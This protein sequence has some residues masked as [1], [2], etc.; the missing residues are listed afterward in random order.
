MANNLQIENCLRLT[1]EDIN[2]E[3]SSKK[4]NRMKSLFSKCYKHDGRCDSHDK[5]C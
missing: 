5:K 1:D 4:K 3:Q 2:I